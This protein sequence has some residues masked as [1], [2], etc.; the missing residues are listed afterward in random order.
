M[1]F[2][3]HFTCVLCNRFF[4]FLS[5]PTYPYPLHGPAGAHPALPADLS[6]S[7]A[8][9]S[10]GVLHGNMSPAALNNYSR[11]LVSIRLLALF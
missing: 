1:N 11:T 5:G 3:K 2:T 6:S 10:Q 4:L 8:A 9:F 7:A